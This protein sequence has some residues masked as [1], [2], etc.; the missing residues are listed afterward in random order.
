MEVNM[1]VSRMS[2]G[3]ARI[4]TLRKSEKRLF[5][6]SLMGH[7]GTEWPTSRNRECIEVGVLV[8]E[9]RCNVYLIIFLCHYDS[10][11]ELYPII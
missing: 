4:W 5:S 1:V 9:M 2:K 10:R 3:K 7:Y 6:S 8:W 11:I